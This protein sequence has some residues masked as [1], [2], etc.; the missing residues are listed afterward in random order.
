MEE[1]YVQPGVVCLPSYREEGPKVCFEAAAC[2]SPVVAADV[3]GCYNVV[4][5]GENGLSIPARNMPSKAVEYWWKIPPEE[6]KGISRRLESVIRGFFTEAVMSQTLAVY[7]TCS[8]QE[9][10]GP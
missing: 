3:P 9:K 4:R 2:A 7:Q 1:I 6:V 8:Q 10:V 5:N